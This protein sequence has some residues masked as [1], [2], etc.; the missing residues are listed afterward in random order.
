[1]E[2]GVLTDDR[3][4]HDERGA[5]TQ[6]P[7][8]RLSVRNAT[9][10]KGVR[11]SSVHLAVA[12]TVTAFFLV[13]LLPLPAMGQITTIPA[14]VSVESDPLPGEDPIELSGL[15]VGQPL[16]R[17][18]A[19]VAIRALWAT[20]RVS[21]VRILSSPV[22]GGVAVHIQLA[23][24][25][26][27]RGLEVEYPELSGSP[28]LDRQEVARSISYFAGM[29]WTQDMLEEMAEEL[30]AAYSRR[31]YPR[32]SVEAHVEPSESDPESVSL[33]LSIN[34]GDPILLSAVIIRGNLGIQES[35]IRRAFDM[36]EGDV[37][38]Q[39]EIDAG[40]T[41]ILELLREEGYFESYI[42]ESEIEA[43]LSPAGDEA[44]EARLV[45]PVQAGA[46]YVIDFVGNR[47]VPD[48]E[49]HEVL[50]LEEEGELSRAIIDSLSLR[51]RDHYRRL[52]FHHARV[53]WRIDVLGANERRLVFRIRSGPRVR[54]DDVI[55]EGNEHFTNRF[56][57]RQINAQLAEALGETGV[58]RAVS[59]DMVSDIG[60][61]GEGHESWRPSPRGHPRLSI[62]PEEVYV[63]EVYLEALNHI[64][65]LYGADG[66]LNIEIGQPELEF[67]DRNRY[68]DVHIQINEGP[69][70]LIRSITFGGNQ[71]L[72]DQ[73]IRR[74]LDFDIGSG[75]DRYE[76]EQTRRAIVRV[77]QSRGY[78]FAEVRAEEYISE[79][80]ISAD[81]I[82]QINEGPEVRIGSILVRGNDQTRTP[83]IRDRIFIQ[84]GDVYSPDLANRS[85]RALIDLGIFT[86]ASIGLV[87]PDVVAD[88]KDV[89]VE[90]NE[91]R[92]QYLEARVG[93]STADGPRGGI[94]YGYRNLFGYA[95]GLDMRFDLSYQVFF[96]GTPEYEEYV[97][98][99]GLVDRLE[100]LVIL[101]LNIPHL[102]RIGRFLGTRIDLTHE[103]DNDPAYAV[104]RYGANISFTSAYRPTESED[105]ERLRPSLST[106]LQ[107]GFSFSDIEQVQ[108]L[109]YCDELEDDVEPELGTNCLE[110]SARNTLNARAPQGEAWF[111]ITRLSLSLDLR[112]SPFNPTRGFFGSV[113]GEHVYSLRPTPVQEDD[114]VVMRSSNL[115][116]FAVTLNGYVPLGFLDIVLALSARFGWVF[117]LTP[118]SHTFPDRFFYLG[119]F[120]SMRGFPEESLDAE[121][122]GETG[123]NSMLNFRA[124]LR[125]PIVS[126]FALGLF[127]DMGNIWRE[128]IN[129]WQEFA[130]RYCIGVGLRYNTPVG[131]LAIDAAMVIDRRENAGEAFGAIH[132][133]IGLF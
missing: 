67:S 69:Q 93:F 120:D 47:Y 37:Y 11:Q 34:E 129:L 14:I 108:F 31:G 85:E 29:P 55:F 121:D 2:T 17:A 13:A 23:L 100:R 46:H 79:D 124:E 74:A 71:A 59:D 102:P 80:Q 88:V 27:V 116:K 62:R 24:N 122:R 112:D 64:R 101:S 50:A 86:T 123:G 4:S 99:L 58:F 53:D 40:I 19:R 117:E 6:A 72:P 10:R 45:V 26:V 113:S 82:Y 16:T 21:D 110:R 94:R 73:E 127:L 105:S 96:L 66:F 128:Q 28:A 77:Y 125:I 30:E 130:L 48:D 33:H 76:V 98:G 39:E 3:D 107:T 7:T 114:E 8:L 97:T 104:T 131:P 22:Q 83:L 36:E 57:R 9:P 70:T 25:Q 18:S 42:E 41:S 52:G 81:I 1:M 119:G 51:L 90:V 133:A 35:A 84:P 126:S 75:L 87:D 44:R 68:L 118:D 61:T 65:D 63:E 106:Q 56:L 111:W 115:I 5:V 15:S 60:V 43:G 78:M 92:P 38:D 54:V 109:P 103:R 91:R 95:L 20:G 49:L 32:A 12:F 89:L 132:F